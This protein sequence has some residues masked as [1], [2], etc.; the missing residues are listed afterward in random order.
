M[1]IIIKDYDHLR[2]DILT[3]VDLD[4]VF[5]FTYPEKSYN[6]R[7]KRYEDGF[8]ESSIA[9]YVGEDSKYYHYQVFK[10]WAIYLYTSLA[11]KINEDSLNCLL[12]DIESSSP[13]QVP[14][15]YFPGIYAEQHDDIT[16]LTKFKRGI[17]QVYTSYGKTELIMRITQALWKEG[18]TVLIMAGGAKARDE[19]YNRLQNKAEDIYVPEYWDTD[20]YIN[21]INPVGFCRSH[22]F[23]ETE[24]FWNR[25][26]VVISEEI[27]ASTTESSWQI[28]RLCKNSTNYWG[29]GATA[30]KKTARR[31]D[32]RNKIQNITSMNTKWIVDI[33][34]MSIIYKKPEDYIIDINKLESIGLR[35]IN[36]EVESEYSVYHEITR[37]IFNHEEYL[38]T[39][40]H[41]LKNTKSLYIPINNLEFIEGLVDRYKS[42]YHVVTITG[43]GYWS[44]ELGHVDLDTIKEL[45]SEGKIKLLA[46][47]SS[48]YRATDF[49]GINNILLTLGTQA[50]EVLQYIGRVARQERF[51]IWYIT[52]GGTWSLPIYTKTNRLQLDLI[53]EY[54]EKCILNYNTFKLE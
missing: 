16:E 53:E 20:A 24:E 47:T 39:I 50:S 40:D 4:E 26:D 34:G 44:S 35:E 41:I 3:T 48:G 13:V 30:E 22:Q 19:I 6:Y 46:T 2:Y 23:D 10:G 42:K 25:V 14:K 11:D 28:I 43:A 15:E 45:S 12:K 33:F 17:M 32:I 18:K 49:R 5:Q 36:F 29:F 51:S 8:T 31:I 37:T 27:E 38:Y 54:Y 9:L 52:P 7:I 21:I 1:E